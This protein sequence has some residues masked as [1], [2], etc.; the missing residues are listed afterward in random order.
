MLEN[1]RLPSLRDKQLAAAVPTPKEQPRPRGR[2][3]GTK[4][5]KVNKT[6]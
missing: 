6:K 3:S 2:P 1:S 5:V 4:T